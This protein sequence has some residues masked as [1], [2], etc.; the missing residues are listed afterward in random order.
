VSEPILV[1]HE[2]R[3]YTRETDA[4]GNPL[5]RIV[6]NVGLDGAV[7]TETTVEYPQDSIVPSHL[8]GLPVLVSNADGSV[9]ETSYSL[10][11][12]CLVATSHTAFNGIERQTYDVMVTD[13]A[14]RL[15]LRG[16]TRLSSNGAILE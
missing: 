2:T 8:R 15:P 4:A 13:A 11:N 12:G 6:K 10:S 3:L 5:R 9:T 14:Y 7:R 16:E 1:S